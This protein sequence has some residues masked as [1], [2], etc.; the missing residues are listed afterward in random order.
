MCLSLYLL[1]QRYIESTELCR[2][3]QSAPVQSFIDD[4]LSC[5]DGNDLALRRRT[6]HGIVLWAQC[7]RV[8]AP[9]PHS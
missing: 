3:I 8:H 4:E 9:Q 7:G 1:A 6:L 5:L 2:D